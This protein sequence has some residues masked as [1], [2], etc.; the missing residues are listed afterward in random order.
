MDEPAFAENLLRSLWVPQTYAK[1][2]IIVISY[3]IWLPILRAMGREVKD[4][5]NT[6]S[7]CSQCLL[8][9]VRTGVGPS[10]KSV[11]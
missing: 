5:V 9:A 11:R 7:K 6:T 10:K 3:P 1:V 2:L 4:A 8:L